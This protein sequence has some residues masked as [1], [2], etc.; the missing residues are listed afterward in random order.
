M[1]TLSMLSYLLLDAFVVAL[2]LLCVWV[3]LK[4]CASFLTPIRRL[5]KRSTIKVDKKKRSRRPTTCATPI[6]R[7]AES[8]QE[9]KAE[10]NILTPFPELRDWS[11]FNT[12]T[13][14]RKGIP[15]H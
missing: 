7:E 1:N 10:T 11:L 9:A 4:R 5:M 14:I 8:V 3:F 2:A 12:P 6:K 15:T 13:C